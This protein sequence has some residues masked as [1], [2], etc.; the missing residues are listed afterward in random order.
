MNKEN[1][2]KLADFLE[3]RGAKSFNLKHVGDVFPIP[4]GFRSTWGGRI[5]WLRL[6]QHLFGIHG[7]PWR[8]CFDKEWAKTDRTSSGV[9]KRIRHLVEAGREPGNWRRQCERVDPYLFA[10]EH[11]KARNLVRLA[12][13]LERLPAPAFVC[14][15]PIGEGAPTTLGTCALGWA[16]AVVP[17]TESD[18]DRAM[19]RDA[20]SFNYDRY[21][22]RAFGIEAGTPTWDWCF[23]S[24][25]ASV[26][27]T[28]AGAAKRLRYV[29]GN[30]GA[31][32]DAIAQM[33]GSKPYMF[34]GGAA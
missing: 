15:A 8:W 12:D 33:L 5:Q 17:A 6:T 26:D 21:H 13:F 27:D 32:K 1:L 20:V 3:N 4:E 24:A 16:P 18:Y 2:L 25:W 29:A 11:L 23:S 31:P 10:H 30:G 34:G 19:F 14:D 9:A 22:F 7:A 28:P